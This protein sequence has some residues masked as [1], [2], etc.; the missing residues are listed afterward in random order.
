MIV[1]GRFL[2]HIF[3]I[4]TI[5]CS[6]LCAAEDGSTVST[7]SVALP[8]VRLAVL[9]LVN[10]SGRAEAISV[11]SPL[12]N[13]YIAR[14]EFKLIDS[15]SLVRELRKYRIRS[16]ATIGPEDAA[17]MADDLGIDYFMLGSIDIYIPNQIPEAAI[18]L[19]VVDAGDMSILWAIST[20]ASGQD[21]VGLLG[22]GRITSMEQLARRLTEESLGDFN[23]RMIYRLA[24]N[25][26]RGIG[27][28]HA[29]VAFDNLSS[30]ERAGDIITM[31]ALSELAA[32]NIRVLEP[33]AALEI[34]RQNGQFPRGEVNLALL[35]QLYDNYHVER[36]ITGSV[37]LF[38]PAPAGGESSTPEIELGGRYLE[39]AT[40]KILA[41]DEVNRR[42]TDSETIFKLGI[43]RSL[44][45]LARNATHLLL[46]KLHVF[47][48]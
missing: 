5:I 20:A 31:M 8:S 21:Y 43:T 15:G 3:L 22:I 6:N 29:L 4:M 25:P 19:R 24:Q 7:D 32:N 23:S 41:A 11:F 45:K 1:L 36:V 16:T 10:Y 14:G 17:R 47:E 2:I 37:D 13:D 40:G 34:F 42:G 9:P 44:G 30:N 33:G 38:L 35:R 27:P 12:I 48:K 18:S 46:E 39:A 26:T 28:L